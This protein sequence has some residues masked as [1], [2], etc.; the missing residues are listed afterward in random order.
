MPSDQS[1]AFA[2]GKKLEPGTFDFTASDPAARLKRAPNAFLTKSLS[3]LQ[4]GRI[5]VQTPAGHCVGFTAKEPGPEVTILL[6]N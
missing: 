5:L 4:K 2:Y 6:N 3:R 1:Q